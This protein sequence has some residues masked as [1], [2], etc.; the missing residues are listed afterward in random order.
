ML[1]LKLHP[2]E[3]P[4]R[5]AWTIAHGTRTVQQNLVVELH[6]PETGLSGYGEAAAIPYFGVTME[7]MLAAIRK[8]SET[9][10]HL[11]SDW[12]GSVQDVFLSL[13]QVGQQDPDRRFGNPR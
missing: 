12:A 5:H 13:D 3:L 9:N 4:L 1:E 10:R 8:D 6:D 2:L 11:K 7:K